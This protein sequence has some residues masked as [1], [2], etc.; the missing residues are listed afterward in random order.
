MFFGRLR[1][2]RGIAAA[3]FQVT[4]RAAIFVAAAIRIATP[5]AIIATIAAITAVVAAIL[6]APVAFAALRRGVLG[7]RK[8]ATAALAE[9]AATPPAPAPAEAPAS[10]AKMRTISTTAAVR[11]AV[12]APVTS[13]AARPVA[14][15]RTV[16]RGIVLGGE[17]LRSRFVRIG[18]SLVF[19]RFFNAWRA[20]L[21]L[22]DV[23]TDVLF[24][25]FA[26]GFANG[27]SGFE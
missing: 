3:I 14:R 25:C 27:F 9:I 17:I 1:R 4:T 2:A 6:V 13:L 12:T 10:T 20:G 16:L 8:I 11:T 24:N 26:A 5:T 15:G 21:G 19:R 23:S 18:L 7:G 22:F